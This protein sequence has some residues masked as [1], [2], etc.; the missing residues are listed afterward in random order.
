MSPLS[1]NA[2]FYI[3]V[4]GLHIHEK[5]QDCIFTSSRFV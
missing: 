4:C 1:T 3:T 2:F 5:P